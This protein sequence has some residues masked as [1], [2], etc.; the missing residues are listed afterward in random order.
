LR[1]RH[2]LWLA[3]AALALLSPLGCQQDAIETHRVAHEE[4]PPPPEA[5]LRLLGAM[6][7]HGEDVWFFKL[8][9]AP[10]ALDNYKPAF[11]AFVRSVRF[12]DKGE[13]I[14]WKLP[15]GWKQLPGGHKE[16]PAGGE[17]YATLRLGAEAPLDLPVDK[18][19]R[20]GAMGSELANI[21]RWRSQLGLPPIKE[22]QLD[23]LVQRVDIG[24]ATATLVD[25]KGPGPREGGKKPPFAGGGLPA[26]HPPIGGKPTY[27][28]PEGWKEIDPGSG[29]FAPLIALKVEEGGASARVTISRSAGEGGGLLLNVNRWRGQIGLPDLDEEQVRDAAKK[30]EVGGASGS[31]FDFTG[32]EQRTLVV[33]A[34]SRGQ[35]WFLKMQGPAD[36][37]GHQKA[38]FDKFVGSVKF[39]GGN[40]G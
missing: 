14:A 31:Y 22:A 5:K 25:M 33:V 32:R 9:G 11:D 24:G 35:T 36:L 7:P 37:V 30:F 39:D 19:A 29:Q 34:P 10:D 17:R 27:T 8:L 26:G 28:V 16:L 38:A 15:D 21:D 3:V 20:V 4:P 12:P 1:T 2:P 6:I 13:P 18:F 23:E 40:G